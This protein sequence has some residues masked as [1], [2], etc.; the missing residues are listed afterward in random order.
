MPIKARVLPRTLEALRAAA[1]ER[2]EV[3][4]VYLDG[5]AAYVAPVRG[6]DG[7]HPPITQQ[8]LP[9]KG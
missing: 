2:G 7:T 4:G 8:A 6:E 1:E 5:L 3:V 9:R